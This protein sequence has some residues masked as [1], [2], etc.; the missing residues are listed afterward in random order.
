MCWSLDD[1]GLR[2]NSG[3]ELVGS[4]SAPSQYIA[5][6]IIQPMLA[7]PGTPPS[8]LHHELVEHIEASITV[9][10]V[11]G[12]V[13]LPAFYKYAHTRNHFVLPLIGQLVSAW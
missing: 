5:Q 10:L 6:C 13:Q 2:V 12:I 11:V 1:M 9:R 3:K 8:A 7:T 4:L